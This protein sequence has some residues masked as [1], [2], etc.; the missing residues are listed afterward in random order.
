MRGIDHSMLFMVMIL[1]WNS[2][3]LIL[4]KMD[5][6][7]SIRGKWRIRERTLFISAFL[8]GGVGILL[9]MYIFR[10]KTKR[11]RFRILIPLAILLNLSIGYLIFQGSTY[12]F[13]FRLSYGVNGRN[14]NR[15]DTIEGTFTKDLL[16]AGTETVRLQLTEDEVKVVKDEMIDMDIFEYPQT[17]K[18]YFEV[19]PKSTFVMEINDQGKKKVLAW[20]A[21]NVPIKSLSPLVYIE[22]EETEQILRLHRLTNKIIGMIEQKQEYKELPEVQGGYQ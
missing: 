22:N 19:T 2:I 21:G 18:R 10:H 7:R 1:I 11:W 4:I 13:G 14:Q 20:D 8:F 9:G 17:F 6:Q 15:L 16:T 12:S 3:T 5:K